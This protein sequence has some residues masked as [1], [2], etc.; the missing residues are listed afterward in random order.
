MNN[1]SRDASASWQGRVCFVAAAVFS[2]A[3]GGT[4]LIYGWNKGTDLPSSLVWAGVSLGVSVVFAFSWPAFIVSLDRKQWARSVMVLV[5]LVVTGIYS[6]SAALGSASGGRMAAAAEEQSTADTKKKAQTA[7]DAAQTEL[8]SIPASR[9]ASELQ[10]L[11]AFNETELASL[12]SSRPV[13]QLQQLASSPRFSQDCAAVNGSL[14]VVC[15]RNP[16][17]QS[18]LDR[19]LKRQKLLGGIAELKAELARSERRQKLTA[20]ADVAAGKLEKLGPSKVANTDAAALSM[21]L[22]ALGI[23]AQADTINRL[24]VLLAVVTIECGGGLSLAVGMA[25]SETSGQ[26]SRSGSMDRRAF[27]PNEPCPNART[28]DRT[29]ALNAAKNYIVKSIG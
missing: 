17:L 3:S 25:L 6:I 8:A 10:V 21:Y 26:V 18:E 4:N 15:P 20:D 9:P 19:A 5:A 16:N 11:I 7:Y 29:P 12:P 1:S 23:N 13:A 24:L 22:Q 27:T 2:L 14:R 28:N